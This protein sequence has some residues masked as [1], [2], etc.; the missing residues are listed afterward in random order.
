MQDELKKERK[1]L[2]KSL[3]VLIKNLR[4]S[5][6]KSI[7]LISN[8]IE[9]SKSVWADLEKGLKDPQFSTLWRISEALDLPL[10]EIILTL[11]K[12]NPEGW[13]FLNK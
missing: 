3:G 13:G 7:N 9:L 5:K 11:E 12:E 1:Y 10:S 4:E 8:E 2:S 6:G